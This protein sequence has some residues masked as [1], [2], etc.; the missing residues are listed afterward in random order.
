MIESRLGLLKN[1]EFR[2]LMLD[3]LPAIKELS[4]SMGM[5]NDP[6]I[7]DIAEAILHDS[8]H[9]FYGAFRDGGE[10]LSAVG[11]VD[12][13]AVENDDYSLV[14]FVADKPAEALL[15]FYYRLRKLEFVEGIFAFRTK[16]FYPSCNQ[17]MIWHSER[18]ANDYY[19]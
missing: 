5:L 1:L 2:E 10:E 12:D 9:Y 8:R 11:L 14:G 13:S 19:V 15:E 6:K 3:D 16:L 17:R 4:D 7:G 18:K